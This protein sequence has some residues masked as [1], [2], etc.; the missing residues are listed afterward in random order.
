MHAGPLKATLC[1]TMNTKLRDI[2]L[3]SIP[4][5]LSIAGG[6]ALFLVTVDNVKN[7]NV[8]D[9]MN[10]ISASLLSI[11]IVFLLYDYSNYRI[12][13]KLND[14]LAAGMSSRIS[15]M[16]LGLTMVL[17]AAAGLRGKL[18]LATLNKM[19]DMPPHKIAQRF[20]ITPPQ[21]QKLAQYHNSLDDIIYKYGK[22]NIL[23]AGSLQNLSAL[24]LDLL[25]LM[26]EAQFRKN[27]HAS[28]KLTISIFGRIADWMDSDASAAIN[29][30]KML[31]QA[32]DADL[33][34]SV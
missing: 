20:R 13:K 21:M 9:L 27:S 6:V 1:G 26:N 16:M 19:R 5:L 3:K 34:Q 31:A 17:R 12:S 14:T 22:N 29:F 30:Q 24:A 11:P 4:Y 18:T 8:S 28:A 23:D 15:A 32:T 2:L 25:H 7:P 33:S 10:N